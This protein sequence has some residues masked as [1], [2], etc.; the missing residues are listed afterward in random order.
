MKHTSIALAL[1]AGLS[2]SGA[3]QAV[4]QGRDLN[5]SIESFEAYYDTD[6]NITWLANAN[7]ANTYLAGSTFA[8]GGIYGGRMT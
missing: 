2:L 3:A 1:L 5:G 6:L 7:L 4:L 8:V